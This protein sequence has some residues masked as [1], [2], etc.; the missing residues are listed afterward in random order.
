MERDLRRYHQGIEGGLGRRKQHLHFDILVQEILKVFR[1]QETE[2]PAVARSTRQ[3]LEVASFQALTRAEPGEAE[4]NPS[5]TERSQ[6]CH[7]ICGHG[8]AYSRGKSR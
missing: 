8:R 1:S 5:P 6:R 7:L 2:Q 3:S 4:E